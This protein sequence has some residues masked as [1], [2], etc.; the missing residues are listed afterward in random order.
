MLTYKLLTANAYL[1]PVF[2]QLRDQRD[3]PQ[4]GGGRSQHASNYDY[5]T[6]GTSTPRRRDSGGDDEHDISGLYDVLLRNYDQTAV[7]TEAIEGVCYI[8]EHLRVEDDANNVSMTTWNYNL[9]SPLEHYMRKYTQ[10]QHTTSNAYY[11]L[12]F[13][14]TNRCVKIGS[15]WPWYW[16]ACFYGSSPPL[17]LW[18]RVA[19]SYRRHRSTTR[20]SRCRTRPA[21]RPT[22][23][24][25]TSHTTT[26]TSS[27]VINDTRESLQNPT[28][29]PPYPQ[30]QNI[31][32]YNS[33][34][35]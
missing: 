8:A 17:A 20:E 5:Y 11:G 33:Y 29:A 27:D 24:C 26:A 9:T 6:Y 10:V 15:S 30:L 13:S 12:L 3:T 4:L 1:N 18:E 25:R 16:T 19:S 2:E 28:G 35:I 23:S 32:Y 7:M 14:L 31:S 21:R 34:V 22:H